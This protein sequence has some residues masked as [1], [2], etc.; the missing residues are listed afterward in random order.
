LSSTSHYD[1]QSLKVSLKIS[2]FLSWVISLSNGSVAS[3]SFLSS[4]ALSSV[5]LSSAALSSAA[6]S[7]SDALSTSDS[8]C[9]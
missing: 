4:A 7:S 2:T 5:P 1:N 8:D 6:L 9:D 3:S